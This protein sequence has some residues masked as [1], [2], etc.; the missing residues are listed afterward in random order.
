MNS[1]EIDQCVE[2]EEQRA[3]HRKVRQHREMKRAECGDRRVAETV[4]DHRRQARTE[5]RQRQAGGILVG[6][7]GQ[8]QHAEQHRRCRAAGNAGKDGERQRQPG[9]GDPEGQGGARQH[10][11]F[12][13]EI[14]HA[15]LFDDQFAE[16]GENQRRCRNDGA[17][18]DGDEQ[19]H[20]CASPIRRTR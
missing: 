12:D 9:K 15:G 20:Q 16:R 14:E 1:A 19:V 8:R 7:E 3:N 13:A 10:H 17:G 11:A 6:E 4:A 5:D 18:E 2:A